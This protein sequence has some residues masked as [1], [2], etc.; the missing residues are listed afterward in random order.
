MYT[1]VSAVLFE[2]RIVHDIARSN[3]IGPF[4]TGTAQR[5]GWLQQSDST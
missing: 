1:A 3:N 4:P 5:N 2:R